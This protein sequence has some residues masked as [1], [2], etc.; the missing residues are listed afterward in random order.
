MQWLPLKTGT[1]NQVAIPDNWLHP[2]Y[3]EALTILFRL[4]NALRVFVYVVLKNKYREKW[5]DL[6]VTS[7]ESQQG[8][9]S[10]IARK[11]QS[12]AN[13]FGYLCLPVS[14]PMMHLTSGELIRLIHSDNEWPDFKIH[15]KASKSVIQNKLDEIGCIRNSL[16]HFR[17]LSKDDVDVLKQN[18][19]H[20]LTTIEL[21]LK[22]LFEC[23]D[24]TPTNTSEDWYKE[25]RTVGNDLC[26][27]S[28]TQSKT[29]DWIAVNLN[30][31]NHTI[32]RSDYSS[33]YYFRALTLNSPSFI[34]SY[35]LL[36]SIST[37][38]FEQV[39]WP[40]QNIEDIIFHKNIR[41]VFRKSILQ[42][43]CAN[44]KKELEDA[45]STISDETEAIKQD[46]LVAGNL[47][48]IG[49]AN[50]S[51]KQTDKD[52]SYLAW[53][54]S[55]LECAVSE[56]HVPEYWGDSPFFIR[57]YISDVNIFPWMP[58][59]FAKMLYP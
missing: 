14:C 46:N 10:S 38:V 6:T 9:I 4:E 16:A 21:Y 25:L 31:L 15:F 29:T 7:D 22:E 54:T 56:S 8:T 37:C 18:A 53:N 57:D 23:S 27:I 33:S 28:F 42:S 20:V 49:M 41:M 19:K 24:A 40:G 51:V 48:Y 43:E 30:Y 1:D 11:R 2:H 12:Q 45:I 34:N 55:G 35:G 32:A 52:A 17:P 39:P 58:S 47:V 3:Y 50:C 44:I 59:G 36:R 13:N 5:K 26:T